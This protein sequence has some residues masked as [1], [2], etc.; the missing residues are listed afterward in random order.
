MLVE[1]TFCQT[2][3]FDPEHLHLEWVPRYF[4]REE[5]KELQQQE[6]QFLQYCPLRY[7]RELWDV[8][9]ETAFKYAARRRTNDPFHI[10]HI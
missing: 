10:R 8:R 5:E 3:R 6:E 4:S 2:H 7:Q 9:E 1:Q